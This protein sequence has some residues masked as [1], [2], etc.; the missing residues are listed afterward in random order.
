MT[1]CHC[2]ATEAQFGPQ[3]ARRDRAR[4]HKKGPDKTTRLLLDALRQSGI[5]GVSLLDI[6]GGIGV[7]PYE[8]LGTGVARGTL[9]EAS[10]AYLGEARAE[11]QQRGVADRME[12]VHG[13]VVTLAS[14]VPE[15]D[16]V[17][18]DRVV[19]CYPEYEPLLVASVS[20]ARG[21]YGLSYPHDRWYVRLVVAVQNLIRRLTGKAFRTFVHP[22]EAIDRILRDHGFQSRF[23]RNTLVWHVG[24]YGRSTEVLD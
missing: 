6:G 9:V 12:F 4:Y 21:L 3:M 22:T 23:Q 19:C 16:V 7:I 13:D 11:A 24:L 17:T 5:R 2:Q 10:S 18:M 15:A 1:C 14:S 20:K 8:L